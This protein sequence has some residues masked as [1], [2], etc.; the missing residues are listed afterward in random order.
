MCPLEAFVDLPRTATVREINARVGKRMTVTEEALLVPGKACWFPFL[1]RAHYAE[2]TLDGLSLREPDTEERDEDAHSP[3]VD[4][5][6]DLLFQD[7]SNGDN[8]LDQ[9]RGP[10]VQVGGAASS[11]DASSK[12]LPPPPALPDEPRMEPRSCLSVR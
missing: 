3:A 1:E 11:T 5:G 10:L 8:D 7:E 12:A 9:H 6:L 2:R 4:T